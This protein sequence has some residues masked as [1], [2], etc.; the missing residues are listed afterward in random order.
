[1]ARRVENGK[2]SAIVHLTGLTSLASFKRNL[3]IPFTSILH[4]SIGAPNL[5]SLIRMGGTALGDIQEGHYYHGEDWY[6]LLY[7]HSDKVACLTLNGYYIGDRLYKVIAVG[8][9]DPQG[10]KE[11]IEE[12]IESVE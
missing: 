1:M 10:M 8:V 4:V 2:G 6:F 7:E 3:E 12:R 5:N 11:I 9:D